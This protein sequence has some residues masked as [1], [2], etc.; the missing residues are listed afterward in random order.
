MMPQARGTHRVH[1][2]VWLR[3][4][5]LQW[6]R[7]SGRGRLKSS[8]GGRW[9]HCPGAPVG[10]ADQFQRLRR[11]AADDGTIS[12]TNRL[13]DA[14]SSST[15]WP[16]TPSGGLHPPRP[17]RPPHTP[18]PPASAAH[19]RLAVV[20]HPASSRNGAGQT[21]SQTPSRL[22]RRITQVWCDRRLRNMPPPT[23]CSLGLPLPCRALR[24]LAPL[25]PLPCLALGPRARLPV[26]P[27]ARLRIPDR[28]LPATAGRGLR[29]LVQSPS[30]LRGARTLLMANA[31]PSQ[32]PS[33]FWSLAEG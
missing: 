19:P 13:L 31:T 32:D 29:V 10:S 14:L 3:R 25:H 12:V 21:P 4:C 9:G 7:W 2:A 11:R 33:R 26:C 28:P 20:T 18:P 23:V 22:L 1:S 6:L 27:S 17:P 5:G 30:R 24:A 8:A 15:F 16:K